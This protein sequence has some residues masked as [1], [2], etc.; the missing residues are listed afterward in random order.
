MA[1]D[2]DQVKG[3]FDTKGVKGAVFDR[4]ERR[5]LSWSGGI[6]H[7]WDAS[8]GR[9]LTMPMEHR[10]VEGAVFDRAERRILSWSGDGYAVLWDAGTTRP[11]LRVRHSS[12]KPPIFDEAGCSRG[13]GTASTCGI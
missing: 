1:P 7:L 13:T 3:F 2:G 10:R 5:I 12:E 4:A 11:L 6:V 9:A 8:T